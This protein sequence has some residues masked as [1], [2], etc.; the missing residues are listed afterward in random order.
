MSRENDS[1]VWISSVALLLLSDSTSPQAC[2][3]A[4][5]NVNGGPQPAASG[6]GAILAR[7]RAQRAAAAGAGASAAAPT[8]AATA[9]SAAATPSAA[10]SAPSAKPAAAAPAVAA[11]AAPRGPAPATGGA[12]ILARLKAQREAAAAAAAAK[13]AASYK[14]VVVLYASQ[15]GTAQEIAKNI[16]AEAEQR[17]IKGR[18]RGAGCAWGVL[19]VR[20]T[21]PGAER[22]MPSCGSWRVAGKRGLLL[23]CRRCRR[24]QAATSSTLGVENLS[25]ASDCLSVQVPL[26]CLCS[27]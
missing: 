14:E 24:C 21:L 16:Q 8:A 23:G 27:T 3:Q 13:K 4:D 11:P 20:G 10:A 5:A 1:A 6:G 18:V 17:G 19:C 9:A 7:L 12:A 2:M 22:G 26:R 15:T 25:A